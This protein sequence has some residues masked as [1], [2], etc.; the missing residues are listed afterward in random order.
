MTSEQS[1]SAAAARDPFGTAGRRKQGAARLSVFSNTALTSFKL[2]TF[3]VTGSVSILSEALHSGLDLVAA[4]MAY[5]AVRKSRYPADADHQFGHGKFESLSG[6]AE[7]ALIMVAVVMIGWSA[8]D[9]LLTHH[10]AVAHPG[11]GVIVMGISAVVNV[12]VSRMLFR[13]SRATDSIA[14]E[15]DAWHLRT[16]VWTSVGVLVGMAAIAVARLAGVHVLDILD[17]LIALGVAVVIAKAAW[18]IMARS[19]D[20]LVDRSLPAEEVSMIEGLLRKHY[21]DLVGY[22][23][24]RTRKA[25]SQR[26]IDLHLLVSGDESVADAHFLCDHLENE[27]KSMLPEAEVLIHVEPKGSDD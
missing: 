6:V 18:D 10:P 2:V 7:G 11:L 26:Y 24:L 23:R 9:R 5:A 12:F 13:V 27:L 3:V 14:L 25:G 20:H 16:D 4:V 17:P 19:W 21:P 15:A 1:G 22:H 8:F